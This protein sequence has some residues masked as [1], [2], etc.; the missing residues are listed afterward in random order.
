MGVATFNRTA[1]VT[2]TPNSAVYRVAVPA[3][4]KATV[5]L[6]PLP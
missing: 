4:M 3:N 2:E 6:V 5:E 1:A